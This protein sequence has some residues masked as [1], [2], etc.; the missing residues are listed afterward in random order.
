MCEDCYGTGFVGR[1]GVYE[2]IVLNDELKQVILKSKTLQEMGGQFRR[3]KMAYL[4]EQALRKVMA[5][6][7]GSNEMVRVL[8]P[9]KKKA[10]KAKKA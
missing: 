8:T 10:R 9:P 5:G 7:T 2:T 3:A 6:T 4:Q 1:V